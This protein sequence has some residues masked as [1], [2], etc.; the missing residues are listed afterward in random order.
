M[1][2]KMHKYECKAEPIQKYL[3]LQFSCVFIV[4]LD[5]NTLIM[6][7][8]IEKAQISEHFILPCSFQNKPILS[9]FHMVSYLSSRGPHEVQDM[10]QSFLPSVTKHLTSL[11]DDILGC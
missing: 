11:A 10:C 2:G 9:T 5:Y 7:S 6:F 4:Y 8:G 1:K 3:N